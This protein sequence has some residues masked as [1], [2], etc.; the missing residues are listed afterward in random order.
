M[1]KVKLFRNLQSDEELNA[2]LQ[3]TNGTLVDIKFCSTAMKLQDQEGH[4]RMGAISSALVIY[5]VK[6][7]S[8]LQ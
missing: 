3:N 2:F 8:G 7:G 6:G 4:A 1:K 5:E